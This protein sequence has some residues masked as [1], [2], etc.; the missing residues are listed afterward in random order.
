MHRQSPLQRYKAMLRDDPP[1]PAKAPDPLMD[2]PSALEHGRRMALFK[3]SYDD[4]LKFHRRGIELQDGRQPT[5]QETHDFA[6]G[7]FGSPP[8][9]HFIGFKGDE[10]TRAC[11]IFGHPD[12]IHR[13]NDPR[14]RFGGEIAPHDMLIYANGSEDQPSRFSFDDS[15]IM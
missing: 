13:H 3:F 4:A 7:F 15:A 14:L 9:L 6:T 10:Y 12:F 8:A 1:Q 5:A 2:R 11:A